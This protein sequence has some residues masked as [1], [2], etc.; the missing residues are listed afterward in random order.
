[1]AQLGVS[2]RHE[3]LGLFFYHRW[4]LSILTTYAKLELILFLVF[5][6]MEYFRSCLL[7]TELN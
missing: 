6:D 7:V 3:R 5:V 1:M 4:S 2:A